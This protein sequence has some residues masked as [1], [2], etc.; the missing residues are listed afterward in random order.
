MWNTNLNEAPVNKN[1]RVL[2]EGSDRVWIADKN[3]KGEWYVINNVDGE[4]EKPFNVIAWREM[5]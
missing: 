5:L 1:L 3:D 2:L 4:D